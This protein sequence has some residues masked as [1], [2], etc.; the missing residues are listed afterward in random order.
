[1]T[2]TIRRAEARDAAA[3]AAVAAVTFPLA[4]P[5]STTEEAKAAFIASSLSERSFAGYLAEPGHILMLAEVDGEAAGYTM[6]IAGE[7]RDPEV[8][9]AIG[10]RPTV[11]LSK[12]YVMPEQH[13]SGVA[14]ALMNASVDAARALGAVSMW[15][16]V[17]NENVR[18]NRFYEK[19]GFGIVGHKKFRLGHVDEDDYVRERAL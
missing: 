4:C 14:T 1:M 3:L 8:A 13:G 11:E 9:L 15:L 6:L 18:A 2:T 19:S 12:M 7:P 5:P 17:N 10:A 16:G